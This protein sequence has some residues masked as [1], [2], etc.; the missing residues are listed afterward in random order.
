[1][2]TLQ[3]PPMTVAHDAPAATA[4]R[5]EQNLWLPPARLRRYEWNKVIG[6]LLACT[7]FAGWLVLQ[8]SNPVMRLVSLLLITVTAWVVVSSIRDDRRHSHGRQIA[9]THDILSITMPDATTPVRLA[10]VALAQ[11]RDDDQP[12][13]WFYGTDNRVLAHLDTDFLADQEQA[14]RFLR[15]ARQLTPLP[16]DVRWPH[17]A[18]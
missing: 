10:D 4:Q 5:V 13:L 17:T 9:L 12:G 6:G 11:W 8:W 3:R 18:A 14:R 15:W 7:I 16:F 1:M 2:S